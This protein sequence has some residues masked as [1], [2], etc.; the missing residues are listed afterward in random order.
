ME[1]HAF[2]KLKNGLAS[3]AAGVVLVGLI[4]GGI[5][6]QMD[7]SQSPPSNARLW[8]FPEAN[9]VMP[10]F[11]DEESLAIA[12]ASLEISEGPIPITWKEFQDS[13]E[14]KYKDVEL[15]SGPYWSGFTFGQEC[16]SLLG[17]WIRGKPKRWTDYGE[18]LF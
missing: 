11:H 1:Q 8:V 7:V 18:W 3:L 16:G 15:P 6:F 4:V 2:A 5:A 9:L 13:R 12:V 10:V 17:V 14:T